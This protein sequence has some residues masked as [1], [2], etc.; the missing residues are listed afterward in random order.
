MFREIERKFLLSSDAWRGKS[1]GRYLCQGYLSVNPDCTVRVR[2]AGDKAF[3]TIKGRN[4]GPVRTE[5]EY[6]IPLKEA[7]AM[8]QE[9]AQR[10]VIEKT[11]YNIPHEGFIWEVD[12]FHGEN[13]GLLLA[14]LEL[15]D[16]N[17]P[18]IRPDW[19]GEEVTG[20]PRYYNSNLATAPYKSWK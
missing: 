1:Q 10:P 12:E 4:A 2:I 13:Q 8:L 5:F 18:F 11:R 6:S 15:E 7:R 17:Q 20:D 3:L 16:E 19:I 14:E 9:L